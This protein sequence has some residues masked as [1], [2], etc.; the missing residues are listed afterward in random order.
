[1]PLLTALP[2]TAGSPAL[3]LGQ[4]DCEKENVLCAGWALACPGILHFFIPQQ[5]SKQQP[6]PERFVDLNT[7]TTTPQDIVRLASSAPNSRIMSV[8][9]YDGMLH[10]FDSVLAKAGVQSYLGYAIHFLGST[11]SWL[12]MIT[13]SFLSRQFMGSRTRRNAPDAYNPQP[14]AVQPAPP[15]AVAPKAATPGSAGKGGKKRR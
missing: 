1:M 3:H 12:I 9:E 6:R 13:I 10:P 15:P 11:P 14:G 4:I 2:Q 8:P 5:T 7:T